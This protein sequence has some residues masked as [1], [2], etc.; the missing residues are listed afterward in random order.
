MSTSE[1]LHFPCSVDPNDTLFI[2]KQ[3]SANDEGLYLSVI[4]KDQGPRSVV[5][6]RYNA[7]KLANHIL[8]LL[9]PE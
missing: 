2:E 4:W 8:T 7:R 3:F 1:L 9:G 6:S 5:L